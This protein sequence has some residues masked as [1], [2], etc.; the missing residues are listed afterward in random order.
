MDLALRNSSTAYDFELFEQK[1]QAVQNPQ[2]K[3]NIVEIPA[4]ELEKNRRHKLRFG[5]A[6]STAFTFILLAG[7]VGYLIYG[8]VQLTMLSDDLNAANK[9][10][11]ENQS[12]YTQLK[13]KSDSKLSLDTVET[14]AT[15]NLGMKKVDQSQIETVALSKGDKSKVVIQDGGHNWFSSMVRFLQQYLS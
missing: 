1:R 10:L 15:Q 7:M 4:E 2:K 3:S 8:Q 9:S 12:I 11:S 13:M 5:K 14:Y 6:F